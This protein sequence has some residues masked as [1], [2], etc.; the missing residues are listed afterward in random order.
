[1]ASI[2]S[3]ILNLEKRFPLTIAR[4]TMTHSNVLWLRWVEEGV[5]GWGEAVAFNVGG[6][7]ETIDDVANALSARMDWLSAASAWQRFTVERRLCEEKAPS[8]LIAAINQAM[9]DWTGKRVGQPVSGLLG[10][11]AADRG[12]ITSVTIGISSP[13]AARERVRQW[14]SVGD[15]RAIKIK[16]G[17]TA[18]IAADQAMFDAVRAEAGAPMR[19]SVDANG[20]WGVEDACRMS[21]WLAERGI[22]YLEQPLA[23]GSEADLSKVREASRLPLFVDESCFTSADVAALASK[24]DGVNIKLMKCG[25]LDEA[26]RMVATARAH[27]MRLLVGCYGNTALGN[28]A[29][30]TLGPFVDYLDLDSHL[31]LKDDPFKGAAF[32]DGRLELPSTPGFGISHE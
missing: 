29:A 6:Y 15:V 27:G 26:F 10:L 17:S 9:L 19:L 30:A 25:G 16:L 14:R 1:M 32:R 24:V 5:E 13:E 3:T 23:R 22:D 2:S 20:G 31:N 11:T 18:G 12:P 8:A 4:G 28:T 21:A 7:S